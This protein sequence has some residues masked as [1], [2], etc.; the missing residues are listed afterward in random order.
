[1]I[2]RG[3]V[4]LPIDETMYPTLSSSFID[5]T[6][7]IDLLAQAYQTLYTEARSRRQAGR[8]TIPTLE[9]IWLFQPMTTVYPILR[10]R[11]LRGA[12]RF[13]IVASI[14]ILLYKVKDLPVSV[15]QEQYRL[16]RQ[17]LADT[18]I[19]G[20]PTTETVTWALM[21]NTRQLGFNDV[22]IW[23]W[24]CRL[25]AGMTGLC[26]EDSERMCDTLCDFILLFDQ[27][28]MYGVD[29]WWTPQ[30][31]TQLLSTQ[32]TRERERRDYV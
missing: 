30:E 26:P 5:P 28:D 23:E 20:L 7:D 8:P 6:S 21:T 12:A 31:F 14:N 16:Y 11:T 17:N 4:P 15:R 19:N 25:M 18:D 1:M 24:A 9:P 22:S 29:G 3:L 13:P 27:E 32:Q 10:Q 2:L